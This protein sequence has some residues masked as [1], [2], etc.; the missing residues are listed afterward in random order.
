[1]F[2][3]SILGLALATHQAGYSAAFHAAYQGLQRTLRRIEKEAPARR[4]ELERIRKRIE[5]FE[6]AHGLPT[7]KEWADAPPKKK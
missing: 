1:M 3:E 7:E 4:A 6:K 5:E 2:V